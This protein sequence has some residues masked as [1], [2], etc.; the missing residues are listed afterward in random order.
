[1]SLASQRD[2][3][4]ILVCQMQEILRQRLLCV[5]SFVI[6]LFIKSANRVSNGQMYR[7]CTFLLLSQGDSTGMGLLSDLHVVGT[8]IT[9]MVV[10]DVPF[11]QARSL[12]PPELVLAPQSLVASDRHPLIFSFNYHQDVHMRFRGVESPRHSYHEVIVG[13]PYVR[14]A[15]AP[16]A[17][18][19]DFFYAPQLFLNALLPTLAGSFW[20]FAKQQRW[21]DARDDA[22]HHI[23]EV[24]MSRH[25]PLIMSF[26]GKHEG[27]PA[28]KGQDIWVDGLM[29]M[30]QMPGI[31][32]P[33]WGKLLQF[34]AR[35]RLANV[36]VQPLEGELVVATPFLNGL[37]V[38]TFRVGGQPKELWRSV[39]LH[40]AWELGGPEWPEESST[41]ASTPNSAERV[42][43]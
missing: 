22:P 16:A 13:L 19:K 25:D 39:Q 36:L 8:S 23:Y 32:R 37:P 1:M 17:K 3:F 26:H 18:A 24:R 14:M 4:L 41:N 27:K 28:K 33:F 35:Q 29:H 34:R 6:F 10:L 11:S 38:G 43:Q 12:L 21:I 5:Q 40:L 7:W 2:F 31:C 15:K 20:G 30:L 42:A 9:S